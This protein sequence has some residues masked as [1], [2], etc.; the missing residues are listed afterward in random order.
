MTTTTPHLSMWDS[1]SSKCCHC[2]QME[3][4][5]SWQ[6]TSWPSF[7]P[8]MM[9]PAMG[10]VLSSRTGLPPWPVADSP[11]MDRRHEKKKNVAD[12]TLKDP[13]SKSSWS[14]SVPCSLGWDLLDGRSSCRTM[15][16]FSDQQ[17]IYQITNVNKINPD[18]SNAIITC[19]SV[20]FD[21]TGQVGW[22]WER[23]W[24]WA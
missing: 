14:C 12:K 15:K 4:L 24:T 16:C 6:Q 22:H 8:S 20:S 18:S 5:S 13:S 23:P 19:L 21:Q 3:V 9:S 7:S 11:T 1:G 2:T 17:G 10:A